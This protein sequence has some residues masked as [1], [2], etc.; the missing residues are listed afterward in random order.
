MNNDIEREFFHLKEAL[1]EYKRAGI[2]HTQFQLC[3]DY[4]L[5]AEKAYREFVKKTGII[6]IW[7]GE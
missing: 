6:G 3:W 1:R 2:D 5:N 4:I 7:K